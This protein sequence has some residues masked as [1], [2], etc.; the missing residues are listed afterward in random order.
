MTMLEY[1]KLVL[2]KVSF[3]KKLYMKEYRKFLRLLPAQE[4]NELQKWQQM[5]IT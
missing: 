2:N 4:V 5:Q 3:D 1:A